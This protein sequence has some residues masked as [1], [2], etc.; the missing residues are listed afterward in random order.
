M[1]ESEEHSEANMATK[2]ITK[3][4]VIIDGLD[5]EKLYSK[6]E[7][8]CLFD[9]VVYLF[10]VS[11][12]RLETMK[13]NLRNNNTES[14]REAQNLPSLSNISLHHSINLNNLKL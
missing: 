12:N 13:L 8:L 10:R 1:K 5:L 11:R 14:S 9:M 7:R 6:M 4:R 3:E 2:Y